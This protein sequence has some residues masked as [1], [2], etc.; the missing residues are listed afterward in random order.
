MGMEGMERLRMARERLGGKPGGKG[1]T[2]IA[3]KNMAATTSASARFRLSK[4]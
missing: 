1:G 2:N 4:Y 3:K